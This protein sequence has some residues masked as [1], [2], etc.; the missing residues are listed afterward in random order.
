MQPQAPSPEGTGLSSAAN[1]SS[2][3]DD[4]NILQ[5]AVHNAWEPLGIAVGQRG[6]D[7]VLNDGDHRPAPAHNEEEAPDREPLL[8]FVR[9]GGVVP[10]ATP[11]AASHRLEPRAAGARP[12][13]GLAA[14]PG[15]ETKKTPGS[16][17]G[18]FFISCARGEL[19]P[20]AL[21]GTGT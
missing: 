20:H 19:N 14:T 10:T 2:P 18:V 6:R 8:H 3:D 9:E 11:V 13:S 5:R 4:A 1:V 15:H 12:Q 21:S 17:L 16:A 7:L